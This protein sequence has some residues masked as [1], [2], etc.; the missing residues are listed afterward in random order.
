MDAK[1]CGIAVLGTVLLDKIN[2]INA[3][4]G[5]GELTKILGTKQ[6]VGGCVPNVAIDLKKLMP[7]LPVSAIGKIGADE[8][9]RYVLDALNRYGIDTS[10]IIADKSDRTS[11]TE[12]MSVLGGQR[13]F[14]TYAGASSSFGISD[15]DL[16]SVSAKMIHL[17]YFL[18]LDRMDSGDGLELLKAA[19]ERGIETSIDLVTENS[20]R[21]SLVLPLLRYVDYLI[22]NEVEAA[23]IL[24]KDASERLEVLADELMRIGNMKK[25]IIHKPDCSVCLSSDGKLT[26][27]ASFALPEGYILGTTGAGDAFCSGALIGIHN[28]YSDSKIL[29]LASAAATLSLSLPDATGGIKTEKECMEFCK[30]FSRKQICL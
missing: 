18:L 22:I 14:F 21:Y 20:E 9:G 2:E 23:N 7:E 17:G 5:I 3:Y 6:S 27:L 28:G 1:R 13:T 25:V 16:D 11:F 30:K 19:K 24:K 4:P 29:E 15:V 8:E 26:T 12:V 10:A